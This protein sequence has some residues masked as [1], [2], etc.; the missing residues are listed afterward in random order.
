MMRTLLATT[1][2]LI[3]MLASSACL[4]ADEEFDFNGHSPSDLLVHL[5][6]TSNYRH[7]LLVRT[8]VRDWVTEDDVGELMELLDSDEP[9]MGVMMGASSYIPGPSTVGIEAAFLIE[10]YKTR[11][12][13]PRLHSGLVTEEDKKALKR[14]WRIYQHSRRVQR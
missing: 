1:L 7:T 5:K 14:W 13:P 9:C 8:S 4:G 12:Y 3:W 11:V 6:T 2:V 10:G